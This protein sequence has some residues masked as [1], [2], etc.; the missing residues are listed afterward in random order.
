MCLAFPYGAVTFRPVC[1]GRVGLD[2]E[3]TSAAR[4]AG[5]HGGQPTSPRPTQR[6]AVEQP[7]REVGGPESKAGRSAS[8][9]VTRLN[10]VPKGLR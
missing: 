7:S 1:H 8:A 9:G 10:R 3:I 4:T 2:P 5:A 6:S